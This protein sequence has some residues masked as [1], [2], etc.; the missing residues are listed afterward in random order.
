MRSQGVAMVDVAVSLL[1]A[2]DYSLRSKI[3][4]GYTF[5]APFLN[6][7]LSD[8]TPPRYKNILN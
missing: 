4:A 2:A 1:A 7:F 8:F 6:R 3:D 5:W